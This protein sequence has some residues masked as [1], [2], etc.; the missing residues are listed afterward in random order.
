MGNISKLESDKFCPANP[1][2]KLLFVDDDIKM[3]APSS[4]DTI[5]TIVTCESMMESERK[6]K[7]AF[8]GLMYARLLCLGKLDITP[9]ETNVSCAAIYRISDSFT[10]KSAD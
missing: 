3:E 1:E 8:Q 7:Q 6:G 5:K 10:K 9:A 2:G 4:T